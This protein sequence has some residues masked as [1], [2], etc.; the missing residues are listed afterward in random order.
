MPLQINMGFGALKNELGHCSNAVSNRENSS[1][2]RTYVS[3]VITNTY[4]DHIGT[5]NWNLDWAKI[6]NKSYAWVL[7]Q[8]NCQSFVRDKYRSV[9]NS[10]RHVKNYSKYISGRCPVRT[11]NSDNETQGLG[12]FHK[13]THVNKCF[14]KVSKANIIPIQNRFEVLNSIDNSTDNAFQCVE[15]VKCDTF[16]IRNA[17][18]SSKRQ[19]H[20]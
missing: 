18:A 6:N 11:G 5:T 4:K 16:A 13:T 1:H 15:T 2:N 7:K 9:K 8:N 19:F 17:T 12:L 10:E 20:N 3:R 14:S